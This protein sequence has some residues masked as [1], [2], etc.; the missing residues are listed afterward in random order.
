MN[1]LTPIVDKILK[2][3]PNAEV[4]KK[5]AMKLKDKEALYLLTKV[6]SEEKIE[7]TF[8]QH[9]GVAYKSLKNVEVDRGLLDNFELAYLKENKFIPLSAE[10]NTFHVAIE[11]IG[12]SSKSDAIEKVFRERGGQVVFHFAFDHEIIEKIEEVSSYKK[13]VET[14]KTKEYRANADEFSAIE[15]V[16]KVI[17]DGIALGASDIHIERLKNETQIRYRVDGLLTGVK[18]FKFASNDYISTINGRIK[19]IS[20]MDVSQSRKSQDGRIDNY[21]Y[22]GDLYDIRVSSVNTIYGEK[23]VMRLIKKSSETVSFK[24]LGFTQENQ[25]KVKRMLKNQNGIIYLAGATGSGKSTTLYTMI[26][27]I[28]DETINIYTIEDP[29]EKSI[30][31]VN[32]IQIDEAAGTDYPT[33]LSALLRQDPNVIVVGEI[34]DTETAELSVRASLTGHLVL[35]TIHANNAVDSISRLID[36]SVESYLIGASSVG[37]LSQRL[38][39]KLCEHCKVKRET[40]HPHEILWIENVR[41]DFDYETEKELGH[42]IYS[43]GGCEH[44]NNGYK[45]R[46]ATVEVLEVDETLRSMIS[47]KEH[48]DKI[49]Q[50]LKTIN[51]KNL[52]YDGIT[53]ALNGITSIEELMGHL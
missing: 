9:Y 36:M 35:A 49:N 6:T 42:Y 3:T 25:E 31:N 41:A 48:S 14:T 12:R 21:E 16:D 18:K 26:D 45:G 24:N 37:M 11:S 50:Y 46:L 43:P 28:K 53:K 20:Q 27:E 38:V 40:L 17:K 30:D 19:V 22:N 23:F 1:Y 2:G 52:K 51:Y 15:W 10:G 34:R 8:F 32:Q 13:P 29:V 44:C 7:S 33:I 39:R 4:I 5:K 47:N